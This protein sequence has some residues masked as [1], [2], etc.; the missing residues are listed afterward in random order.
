MAK[1]HGKMCLAAVAAALLMLAGCAARTAHVDIW[2]DP[3]TGLN[4]SYRIPAESALTY[5]SQSDS[6][7]VTE[8]MGQTIEMITEGG[9]RYAFRTI[10]EQEGN[11]ELE[12][13]VEDMSLDI[14]SPQGNI[15]P[16]LSGILGKS[17]KMI[18][19]PQ[20]KELDVSEAAKLEYDLVAG[21]TRNLQS[22]FQTI[23]PDLPESAVKAGDS[24]PS[25][26]KIE[27]ESDTNEVKIEMEMENTLVGFE[28][29]DGWECA[30]VESKITGT[31]SGKGSQQGMDLMTSGELTG[32]D[33][34]YFA[35]KEGFLVKILSEVEVDA[36]IEVSGPTSMSLPTTRVMN[37]EMTLSK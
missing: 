21:Q 19:S 14:S 37:M 30:R 1:L 2:G 16:D 27:E 11:L 20:G 6:S 32:K 35:Y 10:G 33:T 4:L 26:A 31:V 5:V 34:W 36:T 15:T 29:I 12:V 24:W 9:S 3:A 17:F 23:F 25:Y 18:L 7:E 28:T 13:T 8:V 22:G